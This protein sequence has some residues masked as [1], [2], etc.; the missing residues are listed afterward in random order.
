MI[1][2][3]SGKLIEKQPPQLLLDVN[4]VGYE[5]EAPMSTFYQLPGLGENTTLLTHLV[6]REDAQ[7]LYG[8]SSHGERQLFRTLIK[9]SGV[10]PKLAL[11]VLSGISIEEF[12]RCIQQS[13][14]TGLTRLPGIGKKTAERLIVEMRDKLRDAASSELNTGISLGVAGTIEAGPVEQASMALVSLGYKQ[15]EASKMVRAVASEGLETED[16]I[17]QALKA[18]VTKS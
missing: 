15:S 5:V 14:V 3:L 12:I 2:R 17:R 10:G 4:G 16:I 6:V 11:M 7:L 13:D 8:F 18:S 1:G 9:V